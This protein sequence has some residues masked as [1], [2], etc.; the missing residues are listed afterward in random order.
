M[1]EES[2]EAEPLKFSG[3][4]LI[5]PTESGNCVE[6]TAAPLKQMQQAWNVKADDEPRDQS[7]YDITYFNFPTIESD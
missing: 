2:S 4:K 3:Q 7:F 5:T 1:K 6:T